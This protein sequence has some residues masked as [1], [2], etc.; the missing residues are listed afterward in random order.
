LSQNSLAAEE[1]G[2]VMKQIFDTHKIENQLFI[3]P[4]NPEGAILL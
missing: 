2:I 1:A 4:I 3:S